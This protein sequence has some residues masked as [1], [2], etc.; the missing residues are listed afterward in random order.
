MARLGLYFLRG[1]PLQQ[2]F[3]LT[4]N[5]LTP[6]LRSIETRDQSAGRSAQAARRTR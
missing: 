1:Q 4:L 2:D 3:T 6:N 5:L